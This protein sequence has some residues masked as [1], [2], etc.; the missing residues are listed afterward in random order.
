MKELKPYLVEFEKDGIM[1]TK[2][3]FL[4]Y[5]VKSDNHQPIIIITYDE[6]IFSSMMIFA[7]LGLKLVKYFYAPKVVNKE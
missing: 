3:Y 7:K 6:Y 5:K 4:D 2:N 1:K